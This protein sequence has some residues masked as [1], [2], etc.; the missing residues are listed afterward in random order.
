MQIADENYKVSYNSSTG[1]IT[2]EGVMDL[3]GKEAYKSVAK[4][5]QDVVNETPETIVLDIRELE[6]LNSSG[7]TT[8]GAGLVIKVRKKGASKFVVHCSKAFPWQERSIKG[9]MKLMPTLELK[10]D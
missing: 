9:V 7:I 10:L 1:T 6:F 2:C 4:L 3:R 8:I 5:F